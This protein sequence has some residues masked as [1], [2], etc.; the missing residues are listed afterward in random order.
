MSYRVLSI[1]QNNDYF[2][3]ENYETAKNSYDGVVL[4]VG[5]RDPLNGSLNTDTKFAN[6]YNGFSNS[7]FFFVIVLL[8]SGL[9]SSI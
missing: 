4:R 6:H 7:T 2:T 9:S 3:V 1:S 8:S 5:Y